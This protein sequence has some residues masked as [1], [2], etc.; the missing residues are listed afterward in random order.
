MDDIFESIM[1]MEH[2]KSVPLAFRRG[3]IGGVNYV[4]V[5]YIYQSPKIWK[6][7]YGKECRGI[8][9]NEDTGEIL[10][11][12]FEKFFNVGEPGCTLDDIDKDITYFTAVEKIDGSMIVPVMISGKLYWKTKKNFGTDVSKLA[13]KNL[14][15]NVRDLAKYAIGEGL[16]PIFEYVSH[17]TKVVIDY[18]KTDYYLIGLRDVGDGSL[19]PQSEV[20]FVA[21][22]YGVKRP[23][24]RIVTN[25]REFMEEVNIM[26]GIEGFVLYIRD[27]MYKVKTKWFMDR[28]RI[29]TSLRERDV[30][31][32]V[33]KDEF[34]DVIPEFL[35]SGIDM[36]VVY[37]IRDRVHQVIKDQLDMVQNVGKTAS[38]IS[39]K[40]ERA[41]FIRSKNS[42]L[43]RYMY[44]VANGY[45]LDMQLMMDAIHREE[46]PK[47][48]LN[49]LG[50][51][52]EQIQ[53][54]IDE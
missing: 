24:S 31:E 42:Y 40:K 22:A 35:Q 41:E 50:N 17:D 52:G 33:F 11:R 54:D 30:A 48:T 29:F 28:H 38:N 32:M 51:W 45:P 47:F 27:E 16:T 25:L 10:C 18:D 34:D 1:A 13:A 14:P 39:D 12:P 37:A 9:F 44:K 43:E 4:S 36:N 2:D 20:D 5:A 21:S 8:T 49:Y 53:I 6:V 26:E 23:Q 19:I 7:K 15:D 46:L 3:N